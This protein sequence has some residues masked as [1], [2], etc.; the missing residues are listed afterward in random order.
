[1][2]TIQPVEVAAEEILLTTCKERLERFQS[3]ST[4]CKEYEI[5]LTHINAALKVLHDRKLRLRGD[6][7]CTPD[8]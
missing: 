3:S 4:A 7:E 6:E 5:V 1:M 2:S 8:T